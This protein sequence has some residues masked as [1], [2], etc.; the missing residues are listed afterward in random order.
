MGRCSGS[1]DFKEMRVK[2]PIH[3]HFIPTRMA[4][5]IKP[6]NLTILFHEC[7]QECRAMRT[8]L[9]WWKSKLETTLQNWEYLLKM[10]ICMLCKSSSGSGYEYIPNRNAYICSLKDTYK[11]IDSS[12]I[13]N[14]PTLE[15]QISTNSK[16]DK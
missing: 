7:S 4:K 9:L 15:T 6:E 1:V 11:D 14:G 8:H 12:T 16:K 3:Y 2:T 5:T 13:Q 10:N